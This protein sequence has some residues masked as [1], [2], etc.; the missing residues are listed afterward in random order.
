MGYDIK[1]VTT[2]KGAVRFEVRVWEGGRA[3]FT[4]IKRRFLSEPEAKRFIKTIAH[5]EALEKRELKATGGDPLKSKRFRDR[6]EY[7]IEHREKNISPSYLRD[8][9]LY[10]GKFESVIGDLPI[11]SFNAQ[12]MREIERDLG[13]DGNSKATI[14]KKFA[15]INSVISF[16]VK[17]GHL[18]YNPVAMV[19][20]AKPE[21]P[22]LEFWLAKEAADF[23]RFTRARYPVGSEKEWIHLVYLTAIHT[24]LRSAELWAL[25]P[26]CLKPTLGIFQI[27]E[28]WDL[29]A[30]VFRTLKGKSERQV[31]L[32]ASVNEELQSF[33]ERR[34]I[35][36]SEVI[37][38]SEAG[39]PIDH[40]TFKNRVFVNDVEEWGGPRITMHGL[41]HTAA[42]LFLEHGVNLRVLQEILG[43][44]D[45]KTTQRYVHA[46]GEHVRAAAFA[47]NLA[48]ITKSQPDLGGAQTTSPRKFKVVR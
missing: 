5:R 45:I 2:P 7:W 39:T 47:F 19:K 42:T 36:H 15:W 27:S 21:E 46:C 31:P 33:V 16:S 10:W 17:S 40:N 14:K 13:T 1:R 24:A 12:L 26:R 25:K 11:A 38:Q 43:H 22:K 18:P 37:F 20:P 48:P 6:Y 3:D 23:L 35:K 28:Q 32:M 9:R 4:E 44:K 30:K 41:R 34:G 29:R 8:A